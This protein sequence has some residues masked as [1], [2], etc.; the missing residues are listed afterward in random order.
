MGPDRMINRAYFYSGFHLD[1]ELASRD[2]G[3]P[4][5]RRTREAVGGIVP[6]VTTSRHKPFSEFKNNDFERSYG[7]FGPIKKS[8]ARVFLDTELR[9]LYFLALN[10]RNFRMNAHLA[11]NPTPHRQL[12]GP[13]PTGG[14]I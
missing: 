10:G 3:A 5:E 12:K 8:R 4:R 2:E 7:H 13:K 9:Y 6:I 1:P 11:A 14:V